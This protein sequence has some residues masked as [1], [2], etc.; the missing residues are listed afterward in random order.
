MFVTTIVFGLLCHGIMLFNKYLTYD[1]ANYFALVGSTYK[2]GRWMLGILEDLTHVLFGSYPYSIPVVNGFLTIIFIAIAACLIVNLFCINNK[3]LI[4]AES[5]LLVS[6][7]VVT[8][9]MGYMFTAPY[10]GLGLL[11]SVFGAFLICKYRK[12]Y[13]VLA[14]IIVCACSIGVYQAFLPVSLCI[15]LFY[16]IKEIFDSENA[17]WT[18][19]LKKTFYYLATTFASLGIYVLLN[20]LFLTIHHEQ[21]SDY[22]G[23]SGM[24]KASVS[25]YLHRF[26]FSY[27][28]FINPSVGINGEPKLTAFL[29]PMSARFLYR[30]LL[31][32]IAATIVFL[33][34]LAF[35]SDIRKAF[36][37]FILVCLIPPAVNFIYIVSDPKVVYSLMLYGQVM[38]FVFW[39]WIIQTITPHLRYKTAKRA[40]SVAGICIIIA[41]SLIYLRYDNVCYLKLDLQQSREVSYFTTLVTRIKSV[42]DYKE[43][44]PVVYIN[45]QKINDSTIGE[46]SELGIVTIPPYH[47][48]AMDSLNN[49]AWKSCVKL[50]TGFSPELKEAKDFENLQEV[51]A[52]PSY[53][54]DGSIKVINNTVVVKF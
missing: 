26:L 29:Y 32:L 6:T 27:K 12:W 30:I 49:Y 21:L 11:L 2:S 10:Y 19:F 52:M 9:M 47:L 42:E 31:I 39:G 45:E 44:Y 53:P 14:G 40:V 22:Q 41:F 7:P 23:I 37:I 25:E 17:V 51:K 36:Q 24:G 4:C 50:W 46:V 8:S 35:K 28:N 34:Y 43:E 38:I 16:M 5:M 3:L 18:V 20:K 15:L 1:D 13:S 33:I 48:N 54:N